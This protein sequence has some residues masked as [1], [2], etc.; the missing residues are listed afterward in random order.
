MAMKT[1]K[2]VFVFRRIIYQV[3]SP[4]PI[5]QSWA[6]ARKYVYFANSFCKCNSEA[7]HPHCFEA[8]VRKL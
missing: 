7:M 8:G 1:C 4:E 5:Y 3:S 6:V 2:K